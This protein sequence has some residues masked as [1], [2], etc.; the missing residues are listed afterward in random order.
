MLQTSNANLLA[1][2]TW[3][4]KWGQPIEGYASIIK[5]PEA[6]LLWFKKFNM[7]TSVDWGVFIQGLKQFL[8]DLYEP[9]TA[10][11]ILAPDNEDHLRVYLDQDDNGQA[12]LSDMLAL[13]TPTLLTC[14][15]CS[16]THL[17]L[18]KL[19]C[20]LKFWRTVGVADVRFWLL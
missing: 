14:F 20:V 5:N 19:Q 10:A 6:Q 8:D 11:E 2:K 16:G 7:G 15:N 17:R 4:G 13:Q 9:G 12:S 3:Y 18:S 1:G